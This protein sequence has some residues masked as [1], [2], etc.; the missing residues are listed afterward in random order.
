MFNVAGPLRVVLGIIEISSS[1]IEVKISLNALPALACAS[2]F[3]KSPNNFPTGTLGNKAEREHVSIIRS[4]L[5]AKIQP[6]KI[7]IIK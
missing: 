1:L 3:L 5:K 4:E 7:P 6:T 2:F